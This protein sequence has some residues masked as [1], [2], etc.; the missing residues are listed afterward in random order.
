LDAGPEVA[1]TL[2][3]RDGACQVSDQTRETF[4][5]GVENAHGR[6]RLFLARLVVYH[7]LPFLLT[8]L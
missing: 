2:Q 1:D 4:L 3:G 5:S 6:P 8:F 7:A